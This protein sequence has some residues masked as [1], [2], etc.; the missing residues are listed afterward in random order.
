[1]VFQNEILDRDFF[2]CP[3][4][5]SHEARGEK[6]HFMKDF[7]SFKLNTNPAWDRRDKNK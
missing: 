7:S 4:L 3:T 1:M 2:F 6:K 5:L